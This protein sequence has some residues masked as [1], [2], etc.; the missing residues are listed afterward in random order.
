M[1]TANNEDIHSSQEKT[2]EQTDGRFNSVI[3]FPNFLMHIL[4]IYLEKFPT[5]INKTTFKKIPLDEKELW[6]AFD[7]EDWDK[8]KIVNFI[9]ILLSCR[10]LFD[11]YIIKSNSLRSEDEHWSLW[12][13]KKRNQRIIT[14]KMFSV[15]TMTIIMIPMILK[16]LM[17]ELKTQ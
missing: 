11:K 17:I 9:D 12:E 2:N 1:I 16:K 6:R 3:D 10:H 15:T 13:I 4:K 7:N 8:E 5:G 14:I